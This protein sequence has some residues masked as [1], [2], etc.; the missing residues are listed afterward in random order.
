MDN[1]ISFMRFINEA[2][3][4]REQKK[5]DELLDKIQGGGK[6]TDEERNLLVRLNK[7]EELPYEEEDKAV[8]KTDKTGGLKFDSQGNVITEDEPTKAGQEFVTA[9]GKQRSADKIA[10]RSSSE[11]RIYRNKDSEE[12]FIYCQYIIDS[13]TGKT[14]DFYVYRTGGGDKY[15]YGQFLD[16]SVQKYS[17]YRRITPDILWKELDYTW[18][19]G[20]VLDDDLYEDFMN[21][22]E[23]YR[24][25]QFRNRHVLET[26]KQ[27]FDKLL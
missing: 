5:I 23:L 13:E 8:L 19:Y 1:T 21:F 26:L 7:G 14:S 15:P 27:R 25:N 3:G 24:E 10:R 17:F 18:D 6:L 16:T 4:A 22:V 12:R 20:M 9:K 2:K 11:A